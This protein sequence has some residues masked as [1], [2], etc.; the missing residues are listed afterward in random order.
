MINSFAKK[1]SK[2]VYCHIISCYVHFIS[3]T[4]SSD[5]DADAGVWL[6][7][8]PPEPPSQ[9]LMFVPVF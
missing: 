3:E 6:R 4:Q 1:T 9:H 7:I 5:Y 8:T 2:T